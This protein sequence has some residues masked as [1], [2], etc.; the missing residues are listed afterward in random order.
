MFF[1]YEDQ[2]T[3]KKSIN[4]KIKKDDII[5]LQLEVSQLIRLPTTIFFFLNKQIVYV[6]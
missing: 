5:F 1:K 3:F 6:K 4:V 2:T